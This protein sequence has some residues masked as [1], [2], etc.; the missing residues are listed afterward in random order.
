MNT[1]QRTFSIGRGRSC[2][3]IL[4]HDSV[5]RLHA[6]ISFAEDGKLILTDCKSTCGTF[7]IQGN[8]DAQRLHQE[9]VSPLDELKFGEIQITVRQLIE[10]LQLKFPRLES[11]SPPSDLENMQPKPPKVQGQHLIRCVC[12][13]IKPAIDI[14]AGCGR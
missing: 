6:E 4:A 7:L 12:G 8:G 13:S 14:C 11:S 5:S 3:I 10:T 9:L 2:D 1:K